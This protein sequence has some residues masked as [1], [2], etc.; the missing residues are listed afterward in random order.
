MMEFGNNFDVVIIGAGAAGI[1][2]GKRLMAAKVKTLIV[3]ARDRL[4]GRAWTVPTAIGKPADLGCEWLHSADLNPWTGIAEELGFALDRTLP[5]WASR[6]AI[7]HGEGANEDWLA[8]RDGFEEAYDRAALEPEDKAASEL[9]PKNGRWNALLGAISTWANGAEL[10]LVSVKDHARYNN[11]RLNWRALDGYGTLISTYGANL[12]VC[13]N[14]IVTE[15][16]HRGRN[17][18]IV[19]TA[20]EITAKA[21][22]VT[23]STNIIAAEALRF[24]PVL[25]GKLATAAGLPLGIANKLFLA[26]DGEGEPTTDYRHLIG[27]TERV[28]TG[29]YEIR[30]HGWPMISCYFGGRFAT[31]LERAGPAAMAEFAIGEL[32]G[33]FGNDIRRRL[34]PLASSAW[35]Q[36]PFARGSYSSALPGHA[37]DRALYAAPVDERIFFAGEACSRDQFGTAHAAFTSGV[38]AAEQAIVALRQREGR[39]PVL[40]SSLSSS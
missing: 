8:T 39:E 23:V 35:V 3:E 26:L 32:V 21:V 25:P 19:T 31:E 13:L 16:D 38:A 15:I 7:H 30:P 2:A 14:T 20:N 6:V 28:A 24:T 33:I 1:A 37:D 5:A 27:S 11:T 18:R 34:R 22:I 9:L 29:N 36:D 4:G 10:E 17:L 12:P 40:F